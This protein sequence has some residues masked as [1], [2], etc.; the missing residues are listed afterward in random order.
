TAAVGAGHV[1]TGPETTA[2]YVTDWTGR[3]RGRALAVVRPADTDQVAAVLRAC[4]DA[5]VAVVP[6]G[7]N[8][9]LVGGAVP[10]AGQVLL[11][12]TRLTG[13][14]TVDPAA[15]TLAAPAGR[16]LA[17]AQA[18]AADAGFT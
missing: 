8:T 16:T 18:A 2:G 7:G 4:H 6:Q 17:A 10:A 11:S 12:T 5:G 1:L 13:P 15:R 3:Y 9:G 14:V